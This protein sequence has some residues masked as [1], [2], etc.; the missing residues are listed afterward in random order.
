VNIDVGLFSEEICVDWISIK[1]KVAKGKSLVF[2]HNE[3][4]LP[5]VFEIVK[6]HETLFKD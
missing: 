1:S 4:T 6:P 3:Q 2:P 5:H